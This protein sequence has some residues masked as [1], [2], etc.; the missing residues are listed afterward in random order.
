MDPRFAEITNVLA[1]YF[2][3]LYYSDAERLARER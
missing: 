3:G 1:D 2:D